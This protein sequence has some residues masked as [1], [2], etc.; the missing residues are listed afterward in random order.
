MATSPL[1]RLDASPVDTDGGHHHVFPSM[2]RTL[3]RLRCLSLCVASHDETLRQ[4][5]RMG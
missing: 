5:W 3:P 1:P 4:L 2:D